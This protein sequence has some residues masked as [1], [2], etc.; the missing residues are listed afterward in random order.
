[1]SNIPS[2]TP[3]SGPDPSI[4][5]ETHAHAYVRAGVPIPREVMPHLAANEGAAIRRALAEIAK[6]GIIVRA[7]DEEARQEMRERSGKLATLAQMLAPEGVDLKAHWSTLTSG[8]PASG[9]RR[10]SIRHSTSF[11]KVTSGYLGT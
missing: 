7:K 9:Q 2:K 5:P 1:M 8:S 4:H 3:E 6:D 11:S 10:P